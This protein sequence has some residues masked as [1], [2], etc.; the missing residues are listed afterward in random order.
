MVSGW[1]ERADRSLEPIVEGLAGSDLS[2]DWGSELVCGWRTGRFDARPAFAVRKRALWQDS[3]RR[4][5][6]APCKVDGH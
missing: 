3:D 2:R 1:A 5:G 4:V 6:L